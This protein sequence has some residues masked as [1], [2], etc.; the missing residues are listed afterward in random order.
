MYVQFHFVHVKVEGRPHTEYR[1]IAIYR[2]TGNV[3]RN[4]WF[5]ERHYRISARVNYNMVFM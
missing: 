3:K 1:Y 4:K 5:G 2:S